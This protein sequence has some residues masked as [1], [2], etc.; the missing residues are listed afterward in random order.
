MAMRLYYSPTSP[1][2]RKVLMLAHET[3]LIAGLELDPTNPW[4][5]DT[6]IGTV[7]PLGKVPALVLEDDTVLF[8]S[9][10][11]CEYLDTLHSDEPFF[12]P[13]GP[14]R[15][16]ALRQQ[17]LA[18][19][20]CDATVNHRLETLRADVEQSASSKARQVAAVE[21]AIS[22]LAQEVDTLTAPRLTIGTLA[23][24]VALGYVTFRLSE[25]EWLERYP[26][27][28]DWFVEISQRVSFQN[29]APPA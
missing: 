5:A 28:C 14:S 19:G 16:T 8:D 22:V 7:N 13:A 2:V 20:I 15:W 10:V 24:A 21:R 26:T 29:T 12:P 4:A 6:T 3:G 18:D 27:L 25:L 23:V 9:R 1:Y 11:I 17:A